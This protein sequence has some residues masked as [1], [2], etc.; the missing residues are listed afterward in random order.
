[1][2]EQSGVRQSSG[3][4]HLEQGRIASAASTLSKCN[5]TAAG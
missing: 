4:P 3:L 2:V 1:M 5:T